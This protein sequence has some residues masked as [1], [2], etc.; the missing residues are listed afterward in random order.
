MLT[1]SH[2]SNP[3]ATLSASSS[4]L[5]STAELDPLIAYL[6]TSLGFL[7]RALAPAPLRRIA[8]GA[9]AT[10]G[11]TLWD[12]I[13]T[14][15][16]FSTAGA[17]QLNAD[18]QAVCAAVDK[19]VGP[20]VAEAGLRRCLEAVQLLNLPIKGSKGKVAGSSDA[21]E[22]ADE[23]DAWGA[24]ADAD[25]DDAPKEKVSVGTRRDSDAGGGALGGDDEDD[26]EL[27]LWEVEKRL[28]ADNA[29]ARGVLGALGLEVLSEGEG[30]AVLG[31]RVE[32]AG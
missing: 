4:A 11:S 13:I 17:A 26:A 1:C 6:T 20:G 8:R 21:G 25:D 32:A 22:T 3:W 23:W 7:S 16:R 19:A 5:A 24:D 29:S 9:L 18:L 12:A 30:R 28:F 2:H 15:H 27:G 10:V 31:R 14:R